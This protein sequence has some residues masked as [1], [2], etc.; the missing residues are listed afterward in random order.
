MPHSNSLFSSLC[1]RKTPHLRRCFSLRT[2]L[3]RRDMRPFLFTS[4]FSQF[5]L[6]LQHQTSSFSS[7]LISRDVC[8]V[9]LISS[10]KGRMSYLWAFSAPILRWPILEW[11]FFAFS[12][13]HLHHSILTSHSLSLSLS[14]PCTYAPPERSSQL[15]ESKISTRANIRPAE[16]CCE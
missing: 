1:F 16:K 7:S 2:Y 10:L 13:P 4:S 6:L 8:F 5:Q 12:Y 3:L 14:F 11:L 15:P 9:F